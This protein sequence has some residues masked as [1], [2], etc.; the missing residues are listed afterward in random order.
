MQ[1]SNKVTSVQEQRHW[2]LPG[3]Q[4]LKS[5]TNWPRYLE[6]ILFPEVTR[7]E[8]LY[9]PM[10][11]L[12]GLDIVKFTA[13]ESLVPRAALQPLPTSSERLNAALVR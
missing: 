7:R 13:A 4:G 6:K 9:R 5:N 11:A 12:A 10:T 3:H 2:H 8:R 1:E